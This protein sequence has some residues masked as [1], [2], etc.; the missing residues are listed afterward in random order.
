MDGWMN[1]GMDG[2]MDGWM[3]EG[4]DGWMDGRNEPIGACREATPSGPHHTNHSNNISFDHSRTIDPS[5][6]NSCHQ[7]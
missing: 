5:I 6:N 7:I 1:E 2:W 3:N 4:M